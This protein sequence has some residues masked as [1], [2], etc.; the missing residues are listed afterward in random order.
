MV[1]SLYEGI[2]DVIW[3]SFIEI[4]DRHN[5]NKL[6]RSHPLLDDQ[7][8]S[9]LILNEHLLYVSFEENSEL[10]FEKIDILANSLTEVLNLGECNFDNPLIKKPIFI[11]KMGVLENLYIWGKSID[12]ID[13]GMFYE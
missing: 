2:L 7:K 13:L 9:A 11:N 8:N 12:S 4:R 1:D 6:I 3:I 10:L 5:W